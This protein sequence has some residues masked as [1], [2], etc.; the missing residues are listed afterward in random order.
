MTSFT[1]CRA[2]E[3]GFELASVDFYAVASASIKTT[4]DFFALAT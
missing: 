2:S 3:V 4:G 1:A